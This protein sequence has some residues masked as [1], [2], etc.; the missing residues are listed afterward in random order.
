MPRRQGGAACLRGDDTY[1][2]CHGLDAEATV[3]LSAGSAQ[4]PTTPEVRPGAAPAFP[5][6]IPISKQEYGAQ[7]CVRGAD[8]TPPS[9]LP[10]HR[11]LTAPGSNRPACLGRNGP[12]WRFC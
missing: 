2:K 8:Q 12:R 6:A 7:I 4:T 9:P 10:L 11:W 3:A 1:I 5:T